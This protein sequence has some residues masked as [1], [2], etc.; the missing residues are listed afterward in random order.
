[1]AV[2]AIN[3]LIRP[4]KIIPTLLVFGAYLRIT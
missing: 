4:N 3:D 2:K 1:M